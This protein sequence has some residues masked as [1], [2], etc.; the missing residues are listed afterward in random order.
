MR[1]SAAPGV[2]PPALLLR[3]GGLKARRAF[4]NQFHSI[5]AHS[6]IIQA[7][8][9]CMHDA[10][11]HTHVCAFTCVLRT[12]A[13]LTLFAIVST[14]LQGRAPADTPLPL[15]LIKAERNVFTL[16]GNIMD[17]AERVAKDFIPAVKDDR[18]SVGYI[19]VRGEGD[20]MLETV[21]WRVGRVWEWLLPEGLLSVFAAV[22]CLDVLI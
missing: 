8:A 1:A 2:L 12:A 3:A 16:H 17:I 20:I 4:H 21:G 22:P 10:C 7:L 13:R 11:M 15:V 9:V 5:T 18:V 19:C 14:C 6:V